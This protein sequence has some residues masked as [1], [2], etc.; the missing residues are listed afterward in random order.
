MV[1]LIRLEILNGKVEGYVFC[2]N[3]VWGDKLTLLLKGESSDV[4]TSLITSK[5][6][7]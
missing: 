3:M 7:N 5:V 1:E 4:I 6:C 2:Y